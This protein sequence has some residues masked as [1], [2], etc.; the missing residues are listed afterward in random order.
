M[1]WE[2]KKEE[3]IPKKV[4][5]IKRAEDRTIPETD[6]TETSKASERTMSSAKPLREFEQTDWVP[7][8]FGEIIEKRRP[9]SN[10]KGLVKAVEMDFPPEKHVEQPRDNRGGSS[11][12]F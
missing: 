5:E 9:F 6:H 11:K 8:D 3:P 12:T 2:E 4:E 10:Q 7:I 1:V